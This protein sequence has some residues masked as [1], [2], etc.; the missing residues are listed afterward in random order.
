L[1][2]G[3]IAGLVTNQAT[4][5]FGADV[6]TRQIDFDGIGWGHWFLQVAVPILAG[7]LLLHWSLG[8]NRRRWRAA[9]WATVG[10]LA[11]ATVVLRIAIPAILH[12]GAVLPGRIPRSLG[13]GFTY[14][15]RAAALEPLAGR[16]HGYDLA[17][18]VAAVAVLAAAAAFVAVAFDRRIVPVFAA[19]VA[20]A[21]ITFAGW[22]A[23]SPG[24]VDGSTGY[25]IVSSLWPL[26][27]LG[28][29]GLV[30]GATERE[31]PLDH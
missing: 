1:A 20:G 7:G 19:A 28:A 10:A 31:H 9:I 4:A 18:A 15:G 14:V 12:T 23:P 3:V 22:Y 17:A 21:A 27:V 16:G 8:P 24:G 13:D 5:A 26:L 2:A 29:V 6:Y 25:R 30:V 11:A